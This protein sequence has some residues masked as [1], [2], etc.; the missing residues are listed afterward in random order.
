VRREVV[1]RPVTYSPVS[2]EG[3]SGREPAR[4]CSRGKGYAMLEYRLKC[5]KTN[6]HVNRKRYSS[7]YGQTN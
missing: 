4:T 6:T 3:G 7:G 2:D 1:L 5:V